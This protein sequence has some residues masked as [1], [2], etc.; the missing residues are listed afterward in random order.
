MSIFQCVRCPKA[1]HTRCMDK[2]KIVKLSKKQFIC[3][4]HF[5]NKKDLKRVSERFVQPV[6]TL[7]K[8]IKAEK[9][10]SKKK[11]KESE[12]SPSEKNDPEVAH[13]YLTRRN[14]HNPDDDMPQIQEEVRKIVQRQPK[15]KMPILTYEDFGVLPIKDFDFKAYDKVYILQFRTGVATAAV[16]IPVTSPRDLGAPRLYA[17]FTT[18]AGSR[19]KP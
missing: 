7:K 10:E 6:N 5:K 19:T 2:E 18:S 12:E 11:E 15:D 17:L 8:F 9:V 3:D 16:G 13:N 4:S 1:L 14:R